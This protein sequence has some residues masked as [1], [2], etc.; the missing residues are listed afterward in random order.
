MATYASNIPAID[1]SKLII[2]GGGPVGLGLAIE[3][4]QRGI[5]NV[6]IERNATISPIPKGQ[7][8]TQRTAEHFHFWGAEKQLRAARPFPADFGMG[9]LTTYGELFSPYSYNWL[10]RELVRPFYF[11]EN[12]RLPQYATEQV[13]RARVA[14]LSNVEVLYGW[15]AETI[16]QDAEGAFVDV[17][18][19][20]GS[21]RRVL[22]APYLAGCDGAWSTVR[23]AA[24]LTQTL[25]EHE[26]VMV[27]LVFR[28]QALHHMLKH[29]AVSFISDAGGTWW[30]ASPQTDTRIRVMKQRALEASPRKPRKPRKGVPK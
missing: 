2:V 18:K 16:G 22:R 4:G 27:L 1:P 25:T 9:G 6:V 10:A 3:L 30:Y 15:K 19:L 14:E 26:K 8:L 12:E 29:Q 20:D 7:N 23:E 5:A 24:G 28:S 21:E 11:T 17:A 13:L